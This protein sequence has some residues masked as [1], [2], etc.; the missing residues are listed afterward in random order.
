[1]YRKELSYYPPLRRK[2]K[3]IRATVTGKG[4]IAVVNHGFKLMSVSS[5]GHTHF[6]ILNAEETTGFRPTKALYDLKRLPTFI[7]RGCVDPNGW[8]IFLSE[9]TRDLYI[10]EDYLIIRNDEVFIIR[11]LRNDRSLLFSKNEMQFFKN[12]DLKKKVGFDYSSYRSSILV[13]E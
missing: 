1:M 7:R 9:I 13:Q 3:R 2:I 5:S 6:R 4:L 10:G 11:E 8:V 12:K